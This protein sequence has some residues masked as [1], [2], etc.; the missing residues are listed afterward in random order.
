MLML[1]ASLVLQFL[2]CALNNTPASQ[3]L[4]PPVPPGTGSTWGLA[5]QGA[6]ERRLRWF[7]RVEARK[8]SQGGN[9]V[10]LLSDWDSICGAVR[11]GNKHTYMDYC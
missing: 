8:A 11:T 2:R 6:E 5:A 7:E 9:S 10:T 1:E 3:P 4:S